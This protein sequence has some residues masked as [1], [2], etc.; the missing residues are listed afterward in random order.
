MAVY[1]LRK[2]AQN[3][4]EE[5]WLYTYEEWG[6]AQADSY[7]QSLIS[8]FDWLADS[9]YSGR[10]RDDIKKGYYCFPEG[11]HLIFYT[12]HKDKL[13]IIGVLHQRMDIVSHL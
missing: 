7:L 11:M 4:L 9:P 8:R 12:I 5:I 13:N 10:K 2:L 6:L 3:D 1:I